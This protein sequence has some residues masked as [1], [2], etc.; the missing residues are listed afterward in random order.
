LRSIDPQTKKQTNKLDMNG[1]F[2]N[3]SDI[4]SS[5]SWIRDS[6]GQKRLLKFKH[7]LSTGKYLILINND[8]AKY[9]GYLNLAA[10]LI[11]KGL[12][13]INYPI[14]HDPEQGKIFKFVKD[15]LIDTLR[16]DKDFKLFAPFSPI[17]N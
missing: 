10:L 1:T 12:T 16:H 13:G 7:L 9:L 15:T 5:K 8:Y 14:Y 11:E 2:Y 6:R 4:R 17:V 3:R